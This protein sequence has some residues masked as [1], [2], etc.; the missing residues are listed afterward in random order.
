MNGS[1]IKVGIVVDLQPG[2][3]RKYFKVEII[4]I[5]KLVAS[6]QEVIPTNYFYLVR[7]P[8]TFNSQAID[9]RC[10]QNTFSHFMY[11][12]IHFVSTS[13]VMLH[14][15]AWLKLNCVPKTFSHPISGFAPCLTVHSAFCPLLLFPLLLLLSPAQAP[16]LITSRIH[17]AAS[18]DLGGD[19]FT[20]PEPR[21]GAAPVFGR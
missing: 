19:G 8:A 2:L 3:N 17:C 11:R 4:S 5:G 13:H 18:R 21:T 1:R 14:A 10:E 16:R 9:G 20:D 15:H 7:L 12:H 6:Q